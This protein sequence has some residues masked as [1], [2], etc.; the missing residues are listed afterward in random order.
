MFPMTVN[1]FIYE[2]LIASG[3]VEVHSEF[4]E[5]HASTVMARY[6][7]LLGSTLFGMWG[8][9]GTEFIR[10]PDFSRLE[11]VMF[12]VSQLENVKQGQ[13]SSEAYS[14]ILLK[15]QEDPHNKLLH[16]LWT[17]F[18]VRQY[19]REAYDAEMAFF[20]HDVI[21]NYPHLVQ[22]DDFFHENLTFFPGPEMVRKYAK[23]LLPIFVEATSAYPGKLILHYYL[24]LCYSHTNDYEKAYHIYN[25][26]FKKQI[27]FFS[28][29]LEINNDKYT[30]TTF[31]A[32]V[33]MVAQN[34]ECT[35]DYSKM[36]EIIDN[37]VKVYFRDE[38][39]I[40]KQEPDKPLPFSYFKFVLW[41][42]RANM[43]L[44]KW[45]EVRFDHKRIAPG[46][47]KDPLYWNDLYGDVLDYVKR[48]AT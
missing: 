31:S 10:D 38:V 11:N 39:S 14:M 48:N 7:S 6:A 9:I 27:Y 30:W 35:G 25:Y 3:K 1:E 45:K 42:M 5:P 32:A 29:F 12:L 18:R 15:M 24:L 19:T 43:H 4:A 16:Y 44:K 46:I 20:L 26:L 41:R 8:R 40:S 33:D 34:F 17:Q 36:V 47:N 28:S 13:F 21:T 22:L 23:L 2:E 37:V